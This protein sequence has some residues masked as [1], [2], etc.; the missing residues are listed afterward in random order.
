MHFV[1]IPKCFKCITMLC[2]LNKGI[3]SLVNQNFPMNKFVYLLLVSAFLYASC[4]KEDSI[5]EEGI[6]DPCEISQRANTLVDLY[7]NDLV[8]DYLVFCEKDAPYATYKDS[9]YLPTQ[10]KEDLK[11]NLGLIHDLDIPESDSIFRK[12]DLDPLYHYIIEDFGLQLETKYSWVQNFINGIT[13]TGNEM[14][15]KLYQ[16]FN[17]EV[18]KMEE[19]VPGYMSFIFNYDLTMDVYPVGL[20]YY[21][22]DNIDGVNGNVLTHYSYPDDKGDRIEFDSTTDVMEISITIGYD[23]CSNGCDHVTTWVFDCYPDCSVEYVDRF[24]KE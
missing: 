13:P 8:H 3:N 16:E 7:I 15:D 14:F 6:E 2:C 9:I 1:R 5:M 23:N 4:S 21:M 10:L 11:R 22:K 17:M 18:I 24:D 20:G 19:N 12:L